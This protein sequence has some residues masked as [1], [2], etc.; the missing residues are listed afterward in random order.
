VTFAAVMLA[1]VA[2]MNVIYGIA[3]IDSARVF[4]GDAKYVF[5]DLNTWGWLL[6]FA[7]AVQAFAVFSILRGGEFGRWLGIGAAGLNALLQL[8]WMPAFPFL[9]LALFTLDILVI[10]GLVAY[11]GRRVA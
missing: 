11:G 5:S 4:V 2:T 3:A 9:S 1:L 6:L 7:A 8:L 10:Y